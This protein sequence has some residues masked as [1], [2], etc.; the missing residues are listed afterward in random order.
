MSIYITRKMLKPDLEPAK[1]REGSGVGR[2]LLQSVVRKWRRN[3]MIASLQALDDRQLHDI[4][5]NRGD[6]AGFVDRF[7]DRELQMEPPAPAQ[8]AGEKKNK[9]SKLAA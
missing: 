1:P 9:E 5:L 8:P 7:N 2:G 4:G 3:R 6:I